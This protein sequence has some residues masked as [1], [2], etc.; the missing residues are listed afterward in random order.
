MSKDEREAYAAV[1]SSLLM[2]GVFYIWIS[3]GMAAGAFDGA[4]GVQVWAWQ[5]FK[6]I[7]FGIVLAILAHVSVAILHAVIT[8]EGNED[9]SD[10]RDRLITAR[11]M[12]VSLVV[13]SI[14]FLAMIVILA[15]GYPVHVGLNLLLAGCILGSLCGDLTRVYLYR[16]GR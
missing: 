7:G 1:L 5:V 8:R 2:A 10:E 9:L 15:W 6:L 11:G 14:G 16:R 13:M 4:Q 3:D 12:Q